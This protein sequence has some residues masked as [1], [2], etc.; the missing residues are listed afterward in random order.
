MRVEVLRDGKRHVQE[1]VRGAPKGPV[2][3][4]GGLAE[5]NRGLDPTWKRTH[6]TRTF[7]TA[8][9]R[10]VRDARLQLGH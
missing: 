5:A 7:F 1:F 6:G 4:T 10:D 3:Q 2:K 8:G 9:S